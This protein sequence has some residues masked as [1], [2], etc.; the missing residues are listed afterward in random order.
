M[1]DEKVTTN[2][3]AMATIAKIEELERE[4]GAMNTKAAELFSKAVSSGNA[5]IKLIG[6]SITHGVGGTGFDMNGGIILGED[7]ISRCLY[8]VGGNR[9]AC[10]SH[11]SSGQQGCFVAVCGG[12]GFGDDARRTDIG[13]NTR[14][15]HLHGF[16]RCRH[17]HRLYRHGKAC[18]DSR[19]D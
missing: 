19:Y 15:L 9:S 11:V 17:H 6:D 16:K 14:G 3:D 4:L 13:R 8:D 10:D 7:E 12:D 18:D 5:Q 1:K 2:M